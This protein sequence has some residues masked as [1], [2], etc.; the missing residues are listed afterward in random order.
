MANLYELHPNQQLTAEVGFAAPC[1]MQV[2]HVRLLASFVIIVLTPLT[3]LMVYLFGFAQDRFVS[4][5]GFSVVSE[6][7]GVQLGVLEGLANISGGSK[8]DA[9][10]VHD[11]LD[12]P[13]FAAQLKKHPDIVELFSPSGFDPMFWDQP[14]GLESIAKRW[15]RLTS[16]SLDSRT[17]VVSV[18]ASAFHHKRLE[19]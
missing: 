3:L 11:F 1:G 2:R 6:D 13:A 16:I 17:G 5:S 19:N 18:T 10:I 4:Y 7:A 15:R 14:D 9:S 12:G 8:T